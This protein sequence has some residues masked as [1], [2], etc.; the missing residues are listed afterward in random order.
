MFKINKSHLPQLWPTFPSSLWFKA[1]QMIVHSNVYSTV[2]QLHL[3]YNDKQRRVTSSNWFA[4]VVQV[5]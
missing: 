2:H 1:E 4:T 5:Q 3:K